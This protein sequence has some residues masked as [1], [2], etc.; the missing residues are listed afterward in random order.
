VVDPPRGGLSRAIVAALS[1]SE[2]RRIIY[3]SCDPAAMARDAMLLA[4]AGFGV[5]SW[6]L[7]DTF[8]RTAHMEAVA[9][10]TRTQPA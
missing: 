9:L 7:F 1:T 4:K 8:P 2:I 6:T 5:H 10:F 3:V